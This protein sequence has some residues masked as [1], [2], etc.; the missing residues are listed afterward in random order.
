MSIPWEALAALFVYIIG[1]TVGFIWWMATQTIT[2]QF[3]REDL[4]KANDTLAGMD[5]TYA[6][7]ADMAKE[8]SWRDKKIDAIGAKMDQ[9]K[10]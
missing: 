4:K 6:T 3:V 10:N 1:S 8:F 7:K 9:I 5:A 2:L